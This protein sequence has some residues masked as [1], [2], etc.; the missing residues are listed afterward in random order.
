ML[1]SI[2]TVASLIFAYIFFLGFELPF[3]K[4]GKEAQVKVIVREAVVQPTR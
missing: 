1:A 2:G 3:V 4:L